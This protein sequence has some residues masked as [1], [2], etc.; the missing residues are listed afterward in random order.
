MKFRLTRT[1]PTLGGDIT[2]GTVVYARENARGRFDL[3]RDSQMRRLLA[4]DVPRSQE[5]RDSPY[6]LGARIEQH[7]GERKEHIDRSMEWLIGKQ[8]VPEWIPQ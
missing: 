7:K 8:Y 3:F 5:Y 6:I 2:E 1:I 4:C